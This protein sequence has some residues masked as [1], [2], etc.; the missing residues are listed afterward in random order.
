MDESL[1]DRFWIMKHGLQRSYY[2]YESRRCFWMLFLIVTKAAEFFVGYPA[3]A[4]LIDGKQGVWIWIRAI[5]ATGSCILTFCKANSR[6]ETLLCQMREMG[7]CLGMMP[8]RA[9]DETEELYLKIKTRREKAERKDDV[10]FEVLDAM[11]YNKACKTLGATE[12]WR[13]GSLQKFFGWWLPIPYTMN[14]EME[15]SHA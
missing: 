8:Y 7:A 13:I 11:C 10:I 5:I 12:R 6:R 3:V 2:Y 9:E 15:I 1:T 4:S 14:A